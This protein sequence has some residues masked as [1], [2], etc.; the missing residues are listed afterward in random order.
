MNFNTSFGAIWTR[1]GVAFSSALFLIIPALA[2]IWGWNLNNA[3]VWATGV[4][5]LAYTIETQGMRLEIV[6]QNDIAIRP[7]LLSSIESRPV[8]GRN[9]VEY[10]RVLILQN[11]G[12]GPALFI[13]VN[14]IKIDIDVKG[15]ISSVIRFDKLDCIQ[16]GEKAALDPYLHAERRGGGSIRIMDAVSNLD[17]L[18]AGRSY[19]VTISYEDINGQ[20]YESKVLMGRGGVRLLNH[21][22]PEVKQ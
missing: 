18:F 7:L 13:Q 14:D 15:G 20:K 8:E 1:F 21:G 3:I 4:V 17:P 2:W 22:K 5:L 10:E 6:R 11:I 19:N 9:P 12:R 16:A